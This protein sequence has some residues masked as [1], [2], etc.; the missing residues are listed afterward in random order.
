MCN[1]TRVCDDC[2][3][4]VVEHYHVVFRGQDTASNFHNYNLNHV[5]CLT[6]SK[7]VVN[8]TASPQCAA[9]AD[10]VF[11]LDSSGSIG[12]A[13]YNKMLNFVRDVTSKFDVGQNK[14]RVGVEIFS[15]RSYIQ[16]HLNKYG[17][18]A[19][20]DNAIANIPYKQGT[21]NTGQALKVSVVFFYSF[22][23]AFDFCRFCVVIRFFH[24][25]HNGQ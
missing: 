23:L 4:D 6:V 5:L 1:L 18:S 20:V 15:D 21:T 19:S 22:F 9:Q 24:P 3:N 14:V 13:N 10:I 7:P 2:L 16:F 11:I 12:Q 25:R 17:D 8:E